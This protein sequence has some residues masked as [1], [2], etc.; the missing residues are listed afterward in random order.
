MYE[1]V[2]TASQDEKKKALLQS[3]K[4]LQH[5]VNHIDWKQGFHDDVL[6]KKQVTAFLKGMPSGGDAW[7]WRTAPSAVHL[8]R[9]VLHQ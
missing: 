3:M 9:C 1:K 4:E 6:A 8:P 2:R 7:G 5:A